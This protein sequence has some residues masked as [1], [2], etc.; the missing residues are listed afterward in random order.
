M[1]SND[2]QKKH[3]FEC[4]GPRIVDNT[5]YNKFFDEVF[6]CR[7]KSIKKKTEDSEEN[8]NQEVS[9]IKSKKQYKNIAITGNYGS[10]KSTVV[11]SYF[12]NKGM[13]DQV[14]YILLGNYVS[15]NKDKN[16]A[17]DNIENVLICITQ[18]LLYTETPEKLD[19][20]RVDRIDKDKN[21]IKRNSYLI[22]IPIIFLLIISKFKLISFF[23]TQSTYNFVLFILLVP[24]FYILLCNIISKLMKKM[25]IKKI[26]FLE[27]DIEFY[28]EKGLSTFNK[29]ADEFLNYFNEKKDVNYIVFEDIDRLDNCVNIFSK[30]KELNSIINNYLKDGRTVQFIYLIKD[31]IFKT[32]EN[33]SKFFDIIIPIVPII[34]KS[35]MKNKM[36]NLF[37]EE[38]DFEIIK[39]ISK[40]IDNIRELYDIYNE[41]TVYKTIKGDLVI[42]EK[43]ELFVLSAY[44]VLYPEKFK[45][46]EGGKGTVSY[47]LDENR[48]DLDNI[49][50]FS[51]G[52]LYLDYNDKNVF[53]DDCKTLQESNDDFH[54]TDNPNENQNKKDELYYIKDIYKLNLFEKM[55]LESKYINGDSRA[56]IYLDDIYIPHDSQQILR[57]IHNGKNVNYNLAINNPSIIV[58]ELSKDDFNNNS[59]CINAL[60]DEI[61]KMNNYKDYLSYLYN[62]LSVEKIKFIVQFS[63]NGI[64]DVDLNTQNK[65]VEYV[66]NLSNE[67]IKALFI[68]KI[69]SIYHSQILSSDIIN[70][71]Q[72]SEFIFEYLENVIDDENVIS[73]LVESNVTFNQD[74]IDNC[75]K[76]INAIYINKLYGY[77]F[78]LLDSISKSGVIIPH[79]NFD[80]EKIIESFMKLDDNNQ[81]KKYFK[82][83]ISK[84]Q[85]EVLLNGDYQSSNDKELSSFIKKYSTGYNNSIM[86]LK[87]QNVKIKNLDYYEEKM[88]DD[89][90]TSELYIKNIT[91]ILYLKDKLGDK[92]SIDNYLNTDHFMDLFDK[93]QNFYKDYDKMFRYILSNQNIF[94]KPYEFVV[95]L[96]NKGGYILKEVPKSLTISSNFNDKINLLMK[97]NNYDLSVEDTNI[98]LKCIISNTEQEYKY[99]FI[100]CTFDRY[101]DENYYALNDRCISYILDNDIFN[102]RKKM[103]MIFARFSNDRID[104]NHVCHIILVNG[105]KGYNIDRIVQLLSHNTVSIENKKKIVELYLDKFDNLKEIITLVDEK[106]RV[107]L[108]SEDTIKIPLDSFDESDFDWLIKIGIIKS[109]R[110]YK[111]DWIIYLNS[112]KED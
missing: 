56:L 102:I 41:Y 46:F 35:T 55:I 6:E 80:K 105:Y 95:D 77:N 15:E 42:D 13:E 61:L 27:N 57:F 40:Y 62:N 79:F 71:V 11:K 39:S 37:N 31:D 12:S 48:S 36:R 82:D 112:K 10:G 100:D 93:S 30:I 28:S 111:D 26:G 75:C 81:L 2:K 92:Y 107:L 99:H 8:S 49:N 83:N 38:I 98:F 54:T 109:K 34:G 47:I 51:I 88:L 9:D 17:D 21:V 58:R 66:L 91:N 44:K 108:E 110:K 4:L 85:E 68:S 94:L 64:I 33:R 73:K 45:L 104:K 14:K 69:I 97:F 103:D 50:Y 20:S 89:I 60:F 52:K 74:S 67:S 101:V 84:F 19:L 53:I 1:S 43:N 18:Q 32:A 86:L 3:I 7:E 29:Y 78:S 24:S 96:M 25:S 87:N 90:N 63:S 65:L 23:V 70:Y 72:N 76:C 16:L 5:D 22:G 106:Y 59:I